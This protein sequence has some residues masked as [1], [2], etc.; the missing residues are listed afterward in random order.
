MPPQSPL[1]LPLMPAKQQ[2]FTAVILT[3]DRLESLFKIIEQVAKA[4]SL[5]KV[6]VVWNHQEKAP[7]PCK[8]GSMFIMCDCFVCIFIFCLYRLVVCLD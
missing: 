5:A 2:G 7:P 3:Y 6:L 1:F 4:P 8:P